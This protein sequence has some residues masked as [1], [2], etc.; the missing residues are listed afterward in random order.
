MPLLPALDQLGLALHAEKTE[1]RRARQQDEVDLLLR[2][3]RGVVL[4]LRNG[5]AELLPDTGLEIDQ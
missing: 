1:W 3:L 5:L 2:K 4:I